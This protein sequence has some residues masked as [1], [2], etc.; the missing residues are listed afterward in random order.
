M[1]KTILIKIASRERPEQLLATVRECVRLADS[2]G[3]IHYLFSFDSDDAS[4]NNDKFLERIASTLLFNYAVCFGKTTNKIEAINRDIPVMNHLKLNHDLSWQI[5]LNLSDDQRPIIKGWDEIIR[6]AMPDNLDASLWFRDG[7][8]RINTME[9][10][11]RNYYERFGYIYHPDFKSFYC[12]NLATDMAL[13]QGKCIRSGKQLFDHLHPAWNKPNSLP[14]DDLYRHNQKYWD[15]DK[16]TYNRMVRD[17]LD[18]L[19]HKG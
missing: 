5:L 17:G 9:I 7:Q 14:M 18:K 12:D 2:P 10:I 6:K 1:S 13:F 11:G 16:A 3:D 8:P 15:E 4:Y 19:I